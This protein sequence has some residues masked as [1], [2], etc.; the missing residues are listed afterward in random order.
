[1]ILNPN[2]KFNWNLISF[3]IQPTFTHDLINITA[4]PPTDIRGIESNTIQLFDGTIN[5]F[6]TDDDRNLII[7]LCNEIQNFLEATKTYLD[8]DFTRP[9]EDDY[10]LSIV[11]VSW[12]NFIGNI[13]HKSGIFRHLE[14][15]SVTV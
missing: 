15:A 8:P 2:Q 10:G 4:F 3:C 6:L 7:S 5:I 13:W 9:V 12:W 1:M 14:T 11:E